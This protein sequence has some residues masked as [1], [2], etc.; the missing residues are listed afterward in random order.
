MKL[1]LDRFLSLGTL[2]ILLYHFLFP[3]LAFAQPE[4]E[5]YL[6]FAYDKELLSRYAYLQRR[7]D[8]LERAMLEGKTRYHI[9]TG[10]SSVPWQTDSSPFITA[11]GTW[12]RE[13]VVAANTLPFGTK[14]MMPDLFGDKIFTVEDRMAPKNYHKIDIWFPSTATARQFGVKKLKILVIPHEV[15]VILETPST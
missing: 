9:V 5:P 7:V 13:G 15:A 3:Q 4:K 1:W 11:Q 14:I 8:A 2:I 6:I 12:V 10:Y